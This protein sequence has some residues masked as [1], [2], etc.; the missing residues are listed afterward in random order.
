MRVFHR[1]VELHEGVELGQAR[2]GDRRRH[3]GEE[4]DL[5]TAD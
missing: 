1:F 5:G 2:S 3:G 4:S